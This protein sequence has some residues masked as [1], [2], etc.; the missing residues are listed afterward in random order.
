M[1]EN[2]NSTQDTLDM[3]ALLS[4]NPAEEDAATPEAPQEV[5]TPQ[6]TESQRRMR[7]LQEELDA[8]MPET[9]TPAF[10]PT[11]QLSEEERALRDLEDKVAR[12]RAAIVENA[13]Q[14]YDTTDGSDTILL[15]FLEDGFTIAGNI[16][17]RGQ[18]IEFVKGSPAY[19]QQKDKNGDSWLDLLHDPA[20]QYRRWGRQMFAPGPWP[21]ASWEEAG[22]FLTDPEEIAAAKAGAEAERRRNRRAPMLG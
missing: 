10:V 4:S 19:E 8:P 1:A 5:E 16:W 22:T 6:E 11:S 3:D 15:H 2:E 20:G 14:V 7:E 21:G 9:Q 13:A 12:R 17:Y 18:E